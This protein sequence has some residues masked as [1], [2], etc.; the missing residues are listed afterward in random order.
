MGYQSVKALVSK[1]R[2]QEVEKKIG[3]GEYVATKENMNSP[4][5]AKLLRPEVV[6]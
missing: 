6:D 3:T 5:V 2:G 1:I 4:E